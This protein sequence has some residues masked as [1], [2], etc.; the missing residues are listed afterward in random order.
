MNAANFTTA[1]ASGIWLALALLGHDGLNAIAG[2][3]A[4]GYPDAAQIDLYVVLPLL[5]VISLLACA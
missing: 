1:I 3:R 4:P 5:S 2:Q